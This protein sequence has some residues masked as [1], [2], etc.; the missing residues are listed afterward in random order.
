MRAWRVVVV[1]CA[2]LLAAASLAC[3]GSSEEPAV[4]EEGRQRAAAD[5]AVRSLRILPGDG[6]QRTY[7]FTLAPTANAPALAARLTPGAGKS[8][9]FEVD[10]LRPGS[11]RTKFAIAMGEDG[12]PLS[13]AHSSGKSLFLDWSRWSAGVL[14]VRGN[15]AGAATPIPL[16]AQQRA[17][18]DRLVQQIR[19]ARA[20]GPA[21]TT[22]AIAYAPE[23]SRTATVEFPAGVVRYVQLTDPD[24]KNRNLDS[25]VVSVSCSV[26]FTCRWAQLG[27]GAGNYGV[28][29]SLEFARVV[30]VPEDAPGIE[31]NTAACQDAYSEVS[32]RT[33]WLGVGLVIVGAIATPTAAPIAVPLLG[34]ELIGELSALLGAIGAGQALNAVVGSTLEGRECQEIAVNWV[35]E[36]I[37]QDLKATASITI[38]FETKSEPLLRGCH[39][40]SG[41]VPAGDFQDRTVS[42]RLGASGAAKP[43]AAEPAC[44][45]RFGL[46]LL[47]PPGGGKNP[48]ASTPFAGTSTERFL[49]CSYQDL[50]SSDP[51]RLNLNTRIALWWVEG[52]APATMNGEY[53]ASAD[54]T[55][56][57]NYFNRGKTRV[58]TTYSQ[59]RL[60]RGEYL[61][62]PDT[63]SDDEALRTLRAL[64]DQIATRSIECAPPPPPVAPR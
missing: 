26:P 61:R 54:R 45:E 48:T 4:E 46:P 37:A 20:G 43:P 16:T 62:D 50:K 56:E 29:V 21:V 55:S 57:Y 63:I 34:A 25:R 31:R 14:G 60:A 32:N 12:L 30:E 35:A 17:E 39:R 22:H 47:L 19:A 49:V 5:S 41:I 59:T 3:G 33:T 53:C 15:A 23:G 6:G 10:S 2:G 13:V 9:T 38:C 28:P 8:A 27:A 44:P 52:T 11:G 24:G 1:V 58:V 18:L 7:R 36:D 64:V 40:E 51:A 42:L